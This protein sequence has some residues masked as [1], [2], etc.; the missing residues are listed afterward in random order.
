MTLNHISAS[1]ENTE[2][3]KRPT[4]PQALQSFSQVARPERRHS[5]SAKIFFFKAASAL[6]RERSRTFVSIGVHSWFRKL[7]VLHSPL[8]SHRP[9]S[10]ALTRYPLALPLRIST[11][12]LHNP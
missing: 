9:C 8:A 10:S 4:S 11:F 6:I 2:C 7:P 12:L 3:P 5:L 1:P